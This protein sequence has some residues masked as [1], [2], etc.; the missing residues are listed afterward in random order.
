MKIFTSMNAILARE[1]SSINQYGKQEN[2]SNN[3]PPLTF[4]FPN[5]I[6]KR[7]I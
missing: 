2:A 4:F 7:K 3:M 1:E 5:A 6:C